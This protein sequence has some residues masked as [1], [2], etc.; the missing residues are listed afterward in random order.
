MKKIILIDGNCN[1]C[2]G[3]IRL[4]YHQKPSKFYYKTINDTDLLE[5]EDSLGFQ[6]GEI[7]FRGPKAVISILSELGWFWRIVS[8]CLNVL[9]NNYV[10]YFYKLIAN[11]RYKIFGKKNECSI[12]DRIDNKYII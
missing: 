12:T 3:F 5:S 10:N 6:K 7:L 9:P 8:Y 1:L 11:N 4:V 2:N